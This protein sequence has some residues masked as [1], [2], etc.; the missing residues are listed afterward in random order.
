MARG[1]GANPAPDKGEDDLMSGRGIIV[2]GAYGA[3][4]RVVAAAF[5]AQGDKVARV[6]FAAEAP[7]ALAGA[8]D[9][10]G[11]DITDPAQAGAVVAKAE[12]AFG[13]V[14][15]LVNI[16]GG[17]AWQTLA[18]GDLD[19]WQKLFAMNAM[20]CVTMTKAALPALRARPGARIVN[21]GAGGGL[22]AAAGMGPYAASKSAVHRLTESLAAELGSEDITVN[23][24]LPGIID[25][26][27]N[28][29][30]MPSADFDTWVKPQAIADVIVFLASARGRAIS[31]ALI[32]VAH[33]G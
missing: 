14:D 15:V 21:I 13:Q 19:A 23:A 12:A 25:T 31:G 5:A 33:G 11:V 2:T 1:A 20:T 4:G 30:A 32:P 3:L 24:V 10:G 9:V 17:F 27:A 16:A 26:P 6:D 22:V 29:A 7:G 28:R 8:I 18:D